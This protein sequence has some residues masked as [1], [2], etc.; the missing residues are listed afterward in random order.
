MERRGKKNDGV[1]IEAGEERNGRERGKTGW[2]GRA[3]VIG[4]KKG[5]WEG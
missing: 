4:E 3:K 2:K 1:G 5:E